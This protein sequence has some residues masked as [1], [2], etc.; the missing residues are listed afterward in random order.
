MMNSSLMPKRVIALSFVVFLSA[1]QPKASEHISKAPLKANKDISYSS[2]IIKDYSAFLSK[3]NE[4][5]VR[6]KGTNFLY[7]PLSHYCVYQ[8]D[9]FFKDLSNLSELKEFATNA[10]VDNG[11]TLPFSFSCLPAVASTDSLDDQVVKTLNSNYVSTFEG[12]IKQ[13]NNSLSSF[14]GRKINLTNN[15][16]FLMSEVNV[17]SRFPAPLK[18]AGTDKFYGDKEYTAKYVD[19]ENNNYYLETSDYYLFDVDIN[20]VTMRILLP[21]ENKSI[22]DFEFALL[23]QTISQKVGIEYTL[24][25]F[26]LKN[27]LDL[28]R[29]TSSGDSDIT[30]QN[31][32][33]EFNRY[34]VKA[35]SFTIKGPTSS[36][37]IEGVKIKVN[38]SFLFSLNYQEMPIFYGEVDS[39]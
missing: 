15:G 25:E 17:D 39:L 36:K 2:T 20:A 32:I 7:S 4:E 14:Y 21:K 10:N 23:N 28:T 3:K 19:G 16:R 30:Y 33:F 11:K 26:S 8:L 27:S 38:R 1:C 13:L 12:S 35:S 5:I 18:S 34:G 6:I 22:G 29:A 9:K 31:N 24:P 37:D